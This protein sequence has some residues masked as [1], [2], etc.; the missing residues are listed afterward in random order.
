MHVTVGG[1]KNRGVL[2]TCASLVVGTEV[3]IQNW[4]TLGLVSPK[5][6]LGCMFEKHSDMSGDTAVWNTSA[7]RKEGS[8]EILST[9]TNA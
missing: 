9:D 3:P 4:S 1:M 2:Q 5:Y 8:R 7:W 6:Y